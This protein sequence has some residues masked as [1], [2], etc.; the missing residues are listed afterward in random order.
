MP[1]L[2]HLWLLME[3]PAPL[4][5]EAVR[6]FKIIV[7]RLLTRA[8]PKM[9][10]FLRG[11]RHKTPRPQLLPEAGAAQTNAKMSKAESVRAMPIF[12][13]F[14]HM[15]S[16]E[17]VF[18]I[19]T[20]LKEETPSLVSTGMD[21]PAM[22]AAE[23][24]LQRWSNRFDLVVVL[25]HKLQ[26]D[27]SATGELRTI[28]E[29]GS[30]HAAMLL[31]EVLQVGSSTSIDLLKAFLLRTKVILDIVFPMDG[32]VVDPDVFYN[33]S[34]VTLKL[35]AT[36][37][38]IWLP[39]RKTRVI[40]TAI[41]HFSKRI[42]VIVKSFMNPPQQENPGNRLGRYRLNVSHLVCTLYGSKLVILCGEQL[43]SSG[44][45]EYMVS[46]LFDHPH[47]SIFHNAVFSGIV[48]LLNYSNTEEC[49]L[50]K[51]P[52]VSDVISNLLHGDKTHLWRVLR[53]QYFCFNE[54]DEQE[55]WRHKTSLNGYY[56]LM[57][58]TMVGIGYQFG[59]DGVSFLAN[60]LDWVNTL[61]TSPL[62]AQIFSNKY[63]AIEA[64]SGF[65]DDEGDSADMGDS[66]SSEEPPLM[67]ILKPV[68]LAKR[69][70]VEE[71]IKQ[72]ALT[73]GP[74]LGSPSPER[75]PLVE[76]SCSSSDDEVDTEVVPVDVGY[77]S[78]PM[79]EID[80]E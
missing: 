27:P 66:S 36:L 34:G 53:E 76:E 44:A 3:A 6:S 37:S 75:I 59:L 63:P 54:N 77:W 33:A 48:A 14:R 31:I 2:D 23:I 32:S 11:V 28:A 5:I 29:A 1:P 70:Q 7:E 62:A 22:S 72:I 17:I 4:D 30:A 12:R 69:I 50:E 56:T 10:A 60:K 35:A 25:L 61:Q 55:E 45:L 9:L 46:L 26:I 8:K 58:N 18:L 80:F 78:V 19:R 24:K 16:P 13:M 38:E 74:G 68:K 40:A 21:A 42:P 57:A 51:Y 71:P 15:E 73:V 64:H 65:T 41:E 67:A 79:M 52:I 39:Q 20:A 49:D 47:A 43:I